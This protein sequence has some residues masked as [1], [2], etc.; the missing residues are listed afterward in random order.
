MEIPVTDER[1][2]QQER[3]SSV[4]NVAFWRMLKIK[5]SSQFYCHNCTSLMLRLVLSPNLNALIIFVWLFP[6]VSIPFSLFLN[7]IK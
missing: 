4:R 5:K 3:E 2:L 1:G 6:L 7:K